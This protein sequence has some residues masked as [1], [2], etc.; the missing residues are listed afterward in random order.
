[1]ERL[2]QPI[3]SLPRRS[4]QAASSREEA[5]QNLPP[6]PELQRIG[7]AS[8][9]QGPQ[10]SYYSPATHEASLVRRVRCLSVGAALNG[11]QPKRVNDVVLVDE[12]SEAAAAVDRVYDELGMKYEAVAKINVRERGQ[13]LGQLNSPFARPQTAFSRRS[14]ASAFSSFSSSIDGVG[15]PGTLTYGEVSCAECLRVVA[16]ANPQAGEI[17]CDLGSGRGQVVLAVQQRWGRLLK[18]CYGIEA[19]SGLVDISKRAAARLE[20]DAS[21]EAGG[22][23]SGEAGGEA[24]GEVAAGGGRRTPAT[25]EIAFHASDFLANDDLWLKADIVYVVATC[26][27]SEW[28]TAHGAL[29]R[30]FARLKPGARVC[31]VTQPL[32]GVPGLYCIGSVRDLHATWGKCVARI[33]ERRDDSSDDSSDDS[34]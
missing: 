10:T 3:A 24:S 16:K 19:L 8:S 17:F 20:A 14:T 29:G 27:P 26:F 6:P 33:Y 22:E 31:M 18:A 2:P 7:A 11:I 1:M 25:C 12:S 21:G 4:K 23:A 28:F 15:T 5:K 13:L 30:R 32:S 9:L 34:D